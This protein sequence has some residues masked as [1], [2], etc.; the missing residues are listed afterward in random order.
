M[1]ELYTSIPV[2]GTKYDMI[3]VAVGSYSIPGNTF[4]NL[5]IIYHTT[6]YYIEVTFYYF[7]YMWL[8]IILLVYGGDGVWCGV[9][10]CATTL[11]Y[12]I[13]VPM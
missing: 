8:D 4:M 5:C 9:V 10:W 2:P 12:I 6:W 7:E 13:I 11:R 1:F 3:S